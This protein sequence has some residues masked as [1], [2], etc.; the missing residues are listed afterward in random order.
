MHGW[1]AS[2]LQRFWMDEQIASHR[3]RSCSAKQQ[4]CIPRM[5]AETAAEMEKDSGMTA[6]PRQQATCLVRERL[7]DLFTKKNVQKSW[8][9]PKTLMLREIEFLLLLLVDW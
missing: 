7:C 5:L 4:K 9:Q 1:T 6:D 3:Q 8:W 2:R